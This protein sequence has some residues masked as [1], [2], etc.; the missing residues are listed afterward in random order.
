MPSLID[1][2]FLYLVVC[3][4]ITFLLLRRTVPAGQAGQLRQTVREAVEILAQQVLDG[5]VILQ[6]GN[7]R[8][9]PE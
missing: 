6:R 2:R 4:M 1:N 9:D 8:L 3:S 7:R 5:V